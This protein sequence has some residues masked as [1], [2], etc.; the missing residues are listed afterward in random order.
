MGARV[1]GYGTKGSTRRGYPGAYSSEPHPNRH[2][3]FETGLAGA[4]QAEVMEA[5]L[6]RSTREEK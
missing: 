3:I 5:G 2:L 6:L 4:A 1:H